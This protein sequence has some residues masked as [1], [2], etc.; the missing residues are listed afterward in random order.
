[1]PAVIEDATSKIITEA[2]DNLFRRINALEKS[3]SL[4]E[5]QITPQQI[6]D[7]I[8]NCQRLYLR[9]KET[10][11]LGFKLNAYRDFEKYLIH[12]QSQYHDLLP[13]FLANDIQELELQTQ[14]SRNL[15][16]V[17][18]FILIAFLNS[19]DELNSFKNFYEGLMYLQNFVEKASINLSGEANKILQAT[20]ENIIYSDFFWSRDSEYLAKNKDEQE[21]I[22]NY[23]QLIK[24]LTKAILWDV[25]KLQSSTPK[26]RFANIDELWEHWHKTATTEDDDASL[27]LLE[28][29]IDEE[30][31]K[32][33]GRTFSK[34]QSFFQ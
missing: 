31:R 25:E 10:P 1:M 2:E 33:N 29:G 4:K 23:I 11:F 5:I 26:K 28:R 34:S 30:R 17:Q 7:I 24:N 21:N 9:V 3:L 12:V 27:E 15:L 20:L 13:K 32:Q 22:N 18:S 19:D 16:K 6:A 8:D 14:A